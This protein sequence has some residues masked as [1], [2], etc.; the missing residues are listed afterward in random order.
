MKCLSICEHSDAGEV[1][2]QQNDAFVPAMKFPP[3][4]VDE[5]S[6]PRRWNELAAKLRSR[7]Q[8]RW[9]K[10]LQ[11][12]KNKPVSSWTADDWGLMDAINHLVTLRAHPCHPI[13]VFPDD[14]PMNQDMEYWDRVDE[15]WRFYQDASYPGPAYPSPEIPE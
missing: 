1:V 4:F 3:R 14:L 6:T 8:L 2:T 7:K 5:N 12:F 11:R 9:W 13:E 10:Q 15:R